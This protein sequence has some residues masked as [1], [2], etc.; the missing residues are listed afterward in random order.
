MNLKIYVISMLTSLSLFASTQT[1][2]LFEMSLEELLN[3]EIDGA[4]KTK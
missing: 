1:D 2:A 3:V 4:T